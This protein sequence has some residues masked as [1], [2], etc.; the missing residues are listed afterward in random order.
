MCL[1]D[2][3]G[4]LQARPGSAGPW[5]LVEYVPERLAELCFDIKACLDHSSTRGKRAAAMA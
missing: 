3:D 4:E 2:V 5:I 1:G